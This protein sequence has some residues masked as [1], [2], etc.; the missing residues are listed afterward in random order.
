MKNTNGYA[1]MDESFSWHVRYFLYNQI[2]SRK[3]IVF[4]AAC[5]LVLGKVIDQDIW[6]FTS[7]AY[8]GANVLDKYV[9]SKTPGK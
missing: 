6:M 4:A 2:F 7:F 1:K 8:M 3:F 5:G 9:A